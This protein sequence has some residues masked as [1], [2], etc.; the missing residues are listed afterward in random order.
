MEDWNALLGPGAPELVAWP[1]R[2]T[3]LFLPAC[4]PS[5]IDPIPYSIHQNRWGVQKS[6]AKFMIFHLSDAD[7]LG[8]RRE[9]DRGAAVVARRIVAFANEVRNLGIRGRCDAVWLT[10]SLICARSELG[11]PGRN[12]ESGL[13][14]AGVRAAGAD[15]FRPTNHCSDSSARSQN[16]HECAGRL[17]RLV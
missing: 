2:E 1:C 13:P 11:G 16:E 15:L 3:P 4:T 12:L 6:A 17:M 8:R 5:A 7:L 14:C 10:D 9:R